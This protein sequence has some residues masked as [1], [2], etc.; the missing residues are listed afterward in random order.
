MKCIVIDD[1]PF[2][3]DLIKGYVEKTQILQLQGVFS[4]P[5]K[6]L[7][8]LMQNKTE[9]IFLDINM[10]EL[11]GIQFLKSLNHKPKVIF[12]TAYSEYGVE[13]YD[14]D[15]ID[16]LL[17]PIKYERFL[18]A[19]NKAY[20][21]INGPSLDGSLNEPVKL[22]SDIFMEET[23]SVLIKSGC[24]VHRVNPGSIL[25][26]EAS[27]NYMIFHTTDTKVFSLLTMKDVLSQL[28]QDM[29]IRVHKSFVVSIKCID[30][31]ERG[32]LTIKGNKIPIG[33][34]YREHFFSKWKS[35]HK[36]PPLAGL[37]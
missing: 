36:K 18:K 13:S 14:F 33:S 26:V 35:C 1:E 23:S 25:Y 15:A 16:Y 20:E 3:L 21:S 10:P 12:T 30:V 5:L 32:R 22:S 9:L 2:A 34:T 7:S 27:G 4:N 29:F 28:P 37:N 31:I 19:V 24:K 6:A 8:F 17:K 11:S